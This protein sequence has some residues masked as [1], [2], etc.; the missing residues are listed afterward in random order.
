MCRARVSVCVGVGGKGKNF[1]NSS[2][3]STFNI[4]SFKKVS[5]IR[6]STH[7]VLKVNHFYHYSNKCSS[8]FAFYGENFL[9]VLSQRFLVMMCK[10]FKN[11]GNFSL[12]VVLSSLHSFIQGS[13]KKNDAF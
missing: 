4:T 2:I 10:Y 7:P 3:V 8:S 12:S 1:K 9:N 6:L 13:K 11:K 5:T